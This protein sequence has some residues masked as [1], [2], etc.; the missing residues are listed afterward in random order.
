[1]K[2]TEQHLNQALSRMGLIKCGPVRIG[3][4]DATVSARAVSNSGD[5]YWVRVAP[6]KDATTWVRPNANEEAQVLADRVPMPL[7][8]HRTE[9]EETD[10]EQGNIRQVRGEAFEY[11]EA[12][13]ISKEP[14]ITEAPNVSD[15]WWRQLRKTHDIIQVSEGAGPGRAKFGVLSRI[16]RVAGADV[17]TTGL[18]WSASHGDFHWANLLSTPDL[19]IV[20]WEGYGFAPVGLDAATLLTYS[21]SHPPTADVVRE[22]FSDVLSGKQGFLVQLY[23]AEIV[24]SGIRAGFHAHLEQPIREHVKKLLTN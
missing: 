4:L 14:A 10:P 11:I 24:M 5:L 23:M 12:S 6:V 19:V 17:D 8:I 3:L 16:R 13:P 21:L 2:M 20:D 15:E 22:A 1:M 18:K 7:I 9:W